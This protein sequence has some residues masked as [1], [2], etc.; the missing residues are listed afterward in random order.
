MIELRSPLIISSQSRAVLQDVVEHTVK[1][2]ELILEVIVVARCR[3]VGT[4]GHAS[5]TVVGKVLATC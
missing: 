3:R 5:A 2:R 1:L 4:A